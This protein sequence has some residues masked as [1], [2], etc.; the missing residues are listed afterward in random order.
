MR[1]MN[2]LACVAPLLAATCIVVGLYATPQLASQPRRETRASESARNGVIRGQV[3]DAETGRGIPRA[4]LQLTGG[5]LNGSADEI[6]D[7]DGLFEF[8]GVPAG[9]YTIQASKPT[10]SSAQVPEA[11][12]GR[13][14]KP[15]DLS[16]SST[17]DRITIRLHRASAVTGRVVDQF[18]E[19]V[20]DVRVWVRPFP[21]SRPRTLTSPMRMHARTNDIGEYRLA[22]IA[23]GSYLL[24][25][26]TESETAAWQ[27]KPPSEGG[28]VAYPQASSLDDAQPLAVEVGQS[29]SG[30]DLKLHPLRP[31]RV[32]GV[33][34]GPDGT[35]ADGAMMSV[36][37]ML[38]TDSGAVSGT[39]QALPNGAFDLRLLPGTYELRATS[40]ESQKVELPGLPTE[41]GRRPLATGRVRLAVSGDRLDGVVVQM[42]PPRLVTGRVVFDGIGLA[43]PVPPGE[44]RLYAAAGLD[45]CE[46]SEAR[47]DADFTFALHVQGRRCQVG[48]NVSSSR[49]HQRS[50]THAGRDV[51]FDGV[52]VQGPEPLNDVVI[53]FTDRTTKLTADIRGAKGEQ[54]DAFVVV[55]FPIERARRP[56]AQYGHPGLTGRLSRF[57]G[58]PLAGNVVVDDL[59]PGEYLLAALDPADAETTPDAEWYA[60]LEPLAQ[61]V[62]LDEGGTLAVSLRIVDLPDVP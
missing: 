25:A 35:P 34:L 14:S 11:R 58:P 55:V 28:F 22:P 49:W 9:R 42:F 24:V 45:D 54:P 6:T 20:P 50:V 18:G 47:I 12:L 5:R 2:R 48:A 4:T 57:V 33:V 1:A 3:V 19:P 59:L 44:V 51:T 41:L 32:S 40:R 16:P 7:E 17:L 60:S 13:R 53:T 36:G 52:A 27:P 23:P 38:A 61:R 29:L 46:Y 56:T 43:P 31:T 30:I 8:T 10:Y 15:L 39:G 37:Q 62:T 26:L 21:S